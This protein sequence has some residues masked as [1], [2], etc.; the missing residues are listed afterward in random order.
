MRMRIGAF[1]LNEPLPELNEPDALA[2]LRPW[3]DVGSVG[4]IVVSWMETH[5]HAKELGKLARPGEFFDF[6]RYRPTSYMA[7]DGQRQI[8]VPNTTVTYVKRDSGKD[9]LF[10]H[11]LEPHSHSED[12]IESVLSLLQTF[13]V[14]RYCLLGSMYDYAPHT[15][16][17]IVTGTM[18]QKSQQETGR[19][20]VTR[21]M[22]QGPTTITSLISQMAGSTGI[23]IMSL[24]V[25]L[26]QYTQLDDDY[27]GV[28]RVM[29]VLSS[30]YGLPVDGTAVEKANGQREQID[31]TLNDNPQ[32]KAIIEQLEN[33]YDTSAE[34]RREEQQPKLSPEIEKFLS[35]MDKKFR[36]GQ[37]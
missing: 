2:M 17:L 33:H 26:P 14:K 8:A 37:G 25:H 5:F 6:T 18:G 35:E 15:R 31:S 12:Y 20:N 27:I 9:F 29:E 16:P 3:I 21:S 34:Q 10:L 28:V 7:A 23:D 13:N 36:E 19:L 24:I 32:L 22:Y 1:E 11:L 30:M 4:S